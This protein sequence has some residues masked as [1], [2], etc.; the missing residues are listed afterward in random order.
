MLWAG[1]G[2][3]GGL[4]GYGVSGGDHIYGA[5][6]PGVGRSVSDVAVQAALDSPPGYYHTVQ[7]TLRHIPVLRQALYM[8]SHFQYFKRD[9]KPALGTVAYL[10]STWCLDVHSPQLYQNYNPR[11]G[12]AGIIEC[13]VQAE[14]RQNLHCGTLP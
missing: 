9:V 12:F 10:V 8:W 3:N 13:E 1:G 6:R 2:S 14:S 7:R 4:A 11:L 5:P